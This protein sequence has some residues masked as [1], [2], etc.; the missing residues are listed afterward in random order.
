MLYFSNTKKV[1]VEPTAISGHNLYLVFHG[2]LRGMQI[3]SYGDI[4]K[5]IVNVMSAMAA[6]YYENRIVK[7]PKRYKKYRIV[8]ST[9]E[10]PIHQG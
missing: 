4:D 9:N 3:P 5:E 2:T 10:Q 7:E 1:F 8:T 6:W